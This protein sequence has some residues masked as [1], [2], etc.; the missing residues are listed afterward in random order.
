LKAIFARDVMQAENCSFHISLEVT[1]VGPMRF[2]L[3]LP[4]AQMR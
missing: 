2:A 1:W 4:M 3:L